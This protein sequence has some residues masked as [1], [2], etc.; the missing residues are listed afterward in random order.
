MIKIPKNTL[1]K[2]SKCIFHPRYL[3]NDIFRY[4]TSKITKAIFVLLFHTIMSKLI[5]L[6]ATA[7]LSLFRFLQLP[8]HFSRFLQLP[9]SCVMYSQG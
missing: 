6:V 1:M 8:F 5:T 7:T 4:M 3:H 9:S 2:I